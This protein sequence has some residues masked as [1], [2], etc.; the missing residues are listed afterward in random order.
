MGYLYRY[1]WFITPFIERCEG[2]IRDPNLDIYSPKEIK[3]RR[4]RQA[5]WY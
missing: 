5:S 3:S 1:D 2:L 4:N